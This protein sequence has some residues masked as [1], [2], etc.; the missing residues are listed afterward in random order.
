MSWPRPGLFTVRAGDVLFGGA[1]LNRRCGRVGTPV[2]TDDLLITAPGC[3]QPSM[4]YRRFG[5]GVK[6]GLSSRGEGFE[7]A[8][9]DD[10]GDSRDTPSLPGSRRP[11]SGVFSGP[12]R[13][14]FHASHGP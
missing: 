10:P 12:T 8:V 9:V 7:A 14:E 3:P 1:R 11:A 5:R 6:L 2:N 4:D 13:P